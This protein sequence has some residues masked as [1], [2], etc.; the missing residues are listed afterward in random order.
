MGD[1]DKDKMLPA[2]TPPSMRRLLQ[3]PAGAG[4]KRKS[5]SSSA[6]PATEA[7]PE[8]APPAPQGPITFGGVPEHL[9]QAHAAQE[10]KLGLIKG[11]GVPTKDDASIKQWA[12]RKAVEMLPQ[13]MA[14]INFQLKYGSDKQRQE[15]ADR[16]LDMHGLRK[17]EAQAGNHA[18]IVLNLGGE[19]LAAKLPWLSRS[20]AASE[21]D[22]EKE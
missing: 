19:A 22:D 6:L 12:D 10:W 18:T 13:A 1:D 5:K 4:K 20:D 2:P 17:R 15:A 11:S 9:T 8:P 7:P 16:I 21:G 3:S 14:E